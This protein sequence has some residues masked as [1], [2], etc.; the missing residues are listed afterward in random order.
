MSTSAARLLSSTSRAEPAP[1]AESQVGYGL[2]SFA[3]PFSLCCSRCEARHARG[4]KC[5]ATRRQLR[6]AEGHLVWSYLMDLPCCH[7]TCEIRGDTRYLTYTVVSG[8]RALHAVDEESAFQELRALTERRAAAE[9]ALE[10][11]RRRQP[12]LHSAWSTISTEEGGV[13]STSEAPS[14]RSVAPPAFRT[15]PS[16]DALLA[17]RTRPGP[18]YHYAP[19]VSARSRSL[20]SSGSSRT[21]LGGR[22]SARPD[23]S[24]RGIGKY[25][26]E[27]S[28]TPDASTRAQ[29]KALYADERSSRASKGEKS[30]GR[31]LS[32]RRGFQGTLKV[33]RA[34]GA[35]EGIGIGGTDGRGGGTASKMAP[36]PAP[37]LA[38]SAPRTPSQIARSSSRST[39]AM[40][41]RRGRGAE[42]S[43]R[44]LEEMGRVPGRRV[45][46]EELRRN[47]A[48]GRLV[49]RLADKSRKTLD[50]FQAEMDESVAKGRSVRS[51]TS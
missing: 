17:L 26:A 19:S 12:T 48:A 27:A 2:V 22:F 11:H 45:V 50:P 30:L 37:P 47:E 38:S 44:L 8:G 33:G 20:S 51:G 42:T 34:F 9:G 21:L 1:L 4:L 49:G 32:G 40:D 3:L 23:T 31:A 28:A 5:D 35:R 7:Q 36:P 14:E 13:A 24:T 6:G 46:A 18:S 39:F 25:P 16:S 10:A 41:A 15:A 29:L 43:S